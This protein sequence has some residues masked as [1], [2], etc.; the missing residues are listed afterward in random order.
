LVVSKVAHASF[1]VSAGGLTC[2][3]DPVLVDP[4]ECGANRFDPAVSIDV[5]R[6]VS[7][8]DVVVLSHR[9]ID[10]FSIRSLD[11]FDRG[12]RWTA[13]RRWRACRPRMPSGCRRSESSTSLPSPRG[14]VSRIASDK[15]VRSAKPRSLEPGNYTVVLEPAAVADLLQFLMW[16]LDARHA[17]EGRSFFSKANGSTKLGDKLFPESIH[18]LARAQGDVHHGLDARRGLL[19]EDGRVTAPVNNLRFNESPANVLANCDAMTATTTRVPD[20]DVWRVPALRTHE[21]NIASVS[22]AV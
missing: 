6:L 14:A 4:F 19:I 10:H 22:T 20:G 8:C 17:D 11:L 13:P 7:S 5:D 21:F 9:R 18:A 2:I 12:P 3:T 1:M 16:S 15:G